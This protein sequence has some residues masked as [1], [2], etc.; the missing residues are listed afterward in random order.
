MVQLVEILSHGVM[1]DKDLLNQHRQH[2]GG[3]Y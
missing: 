1:E 2:Q 3:G